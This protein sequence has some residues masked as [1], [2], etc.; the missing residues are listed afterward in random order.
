MAGH[1]MR[2]R[3]GG[4]RGDDMHLAGLDW[5]DAHWLG[6]AVLVILLSITDAFMTLTLMRHGA[7]EVNP[8]MAPLIAGGGPAFAYWKLGLTIF[9]VFVLVALARVRLF[10]FIPTGWFLYLA[11][12]GYIVL[13][14]YE[15]Y[16][17]HHHA[18]DDVS[19]WRAV[20]LHL[21]T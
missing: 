8:M 19:Y 14:A 15:W 3:F 6:A 1:W 7:Q 13:V 10:G 16:L 11:A 9:G 18:T 12:V 21:A 2:R 17:L 20:P 4:R 5:H